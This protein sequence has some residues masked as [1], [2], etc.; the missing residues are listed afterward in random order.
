MGLAATLG[1]RQN[2]GNK[3]TVKQWEPDSRKSRAGKCASPMKANFETVLDRASRCRPHRLG[4]EI[5][6]APRRALTSSPRSPAERGLCARH[7]HDG[8]AM[9]RTRR[10][11]P[12]CARDVEL[13]ARYRQR[14]QRRR[15]GQ[16]PVLAMRSNP[17]RCRPHPI[18]CVASRRIRRL[19][20]RLLVAF[21]PQTGLP[22]R[23]RTL[24]YDNVWATSLRPGL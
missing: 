1:H 15:R 14:E 12:P 16:Q 7:R 24:D 11:N 18:S 19:R 9:R 6:L 8:H 20:T 17:D 13:A 2:C 10:W 3:G 22:A 4:E 21:D 23:V 5:R